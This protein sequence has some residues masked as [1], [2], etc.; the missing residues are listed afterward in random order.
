[1]KFYCKKV[2]SLIHCRGRHRNKQTDERIDSRKS[3]D[4]ALHS[5]SSHCSRSKNDEVLVNHLVHVFLLIFICRND[6]SRWPWSRYA[7]F[8]VAITCQHSFVQSRSSNAYFKKIPFQRA[9]YMG[10][11]PNNVLQCCTIWKNFASIARTKTAKEMETIIW[12][13]FLYQHNP[14]GSM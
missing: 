7:M 5:L 3:L 13:V 2:L 11:F 6:W 12:M 9:G 1:M 10:W 14:F 8:A 4:T